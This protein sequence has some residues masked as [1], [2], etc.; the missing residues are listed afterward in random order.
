MFF[1]CFC[2]RSWMLTNLK[3]KKNKFHWNIYI[4]HPELTLAFSG[5]LKIELSS[6]CCYLKCLTDTLRMPSSLVISCQINWTFYSILY[7]DFRSTN[8]KASKENS[9]TRKERGNAVVLEQHP[10]AFWLCWGGLDMNLKLQLPQLITDVPL[11]LNSCRKY[12]II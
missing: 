12:C 3:Q 9:Q 1:L 4:L 10:P 8:W 7:P 6:P 5:S 11:C 2:V